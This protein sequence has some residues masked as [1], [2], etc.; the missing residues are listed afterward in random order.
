MHLSGCELRVHLSRVVDN[1]RYLNKASGK[2]ECAAVV[3]ANAYGL[4]ALEIAL[5]LHEAGCRTFMLASIAEA[6]VL[7]AV[8]PEVELGVLSGVQRGD[9]P[10]FVSVNATPVLCSMPMLRRWIE[11]SSKNTVPP[12]A[13]KLDTGMGRLGLSAPEF[14]ELL[15]EPDLLAAA[16]VEWIYS[17]LA[18]ADIPGHALNQIQLQRFSACKEALLAI[19]PSLK[20]CLANSAGIYL[21]AEYHFDRVRPGIALYGGSAGLPGAEGI[22]GV[23]ALGLPIIQ[24]K[25]IAAGESVGYGATHTFNE[26]AKVAIVAG[27]YADGIFRV[28]SNKGVGYIR[29]QRVAVVGRVSMDSIIFNVGNLDFHPTEGE[30]IEVLG[31]NI[32]VDA[33]AENAGTISY[34]I[35]T[36]LG[37]RYRR[38]Y[39]RD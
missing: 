11:F 28:L 14:T 16:G 13:L 33:M 22:Q 35:L 8:L 17:H 25:E 18:C 31:R 30:L 5:S 12:S 3:K 4:G 32:G 19:H 2:A 6:E 20:F 38:I 23:V 34:E 1:W 24:L 26:A 15:A 39:L 10:L 36:S 9:E 29:G 7:R 27:G 37:N 21:G